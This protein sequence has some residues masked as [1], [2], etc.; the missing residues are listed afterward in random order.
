MAWPSSSL[1]LSLGRHPRALQGSARRRNT[2]GGRSYVGWMCCRGA[3]SPSAELNRSI[4]RPSFPQFHGEKRPNEAHPPPGS[5]SFFKEVKI[6][7]SLTRSQAVALLKSSHHI[8]CAETFRLHLPLLLDHHLQTK[9]PIR[10]PLKAPFPPPLFPLPPSALLWLMQPMIPSRISQVSS[11]V[12]S[13]LLQS[14]PLPGMQVQRCWQFSFR[15][16]WLGCR[17]RGCEV[18]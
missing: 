16:D 13:W 6:R 5:L 14:N 12:H 3:Q 15:T 2:H 4:F 8:S 1:H 7:Q 18:L 9:H 10:S 17:V 11:S